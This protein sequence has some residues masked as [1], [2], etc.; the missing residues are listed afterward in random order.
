MASQEVTDDLND[1]WSGSGKYRSAVRSNIP[2]VTEV[3]STGDEVFNGTFKLGF[4]DGLNDDDFVKTS[5][6]RHIFSLDGDIIEYDEEGNEVT[7]IT[8]LDGEDVTPTSADMKVYN[9][10]GQFMGSSLESLS[11]GMYIVNG[12][13]IVVK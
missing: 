5:G 3:L 9:L 13:K 8:R 12:K 7:G 6:S 11:K 2:I 1:R 10:E 4:L